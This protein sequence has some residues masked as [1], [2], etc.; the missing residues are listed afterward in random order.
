[1]QFLYSGKSGDYYELLFFGLAWLVLG[2]F[3]PAL[4]GFLTVSGRSREV[5]PLTL[6]ILV[7]S[8]SMGVPGVMLFGS[9]GWLAALVLSTFVVLHS[10]Y[11][12]WR[13]EYGR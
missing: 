1:V 11:K 4:T 3:G 8:V 6:K 13:R 7:L 5:W 2:I 10:G 9:A 12:I